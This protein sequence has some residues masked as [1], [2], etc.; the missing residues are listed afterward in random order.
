[1]RN[2]H[3]D[4]RLGLALA[5]AAVLLGLGNPGG[6]LAAQARVQ[7]ELLGLSATSYGWLL[8]AGGVGGIAVI[9]AAFWV[10][11]KPPHTIMAAG[12]LVALL[13]LSIFALPAS[14]W[15]YAAGM[16]VAGA[17]SSAVSSLIFYA[18]AV[19][20]AARYR[21][22]MIGA[23]GMV[24]LYRPNTYD[25]SD[26][27]IGDFVLFP[28]VIVASALAGAALLLVVLPRVFAGA[29]EPDQTQRASPG[30]P[31][32]WRALICAIAAYSAA[33]G[34]GIII[35]LQIFGLTE[36]ST[37]ELDA[38]GL[39]FPIAP[40]FHAVSAVS[41]LLWGAA[42]DF[43]ALR[44][45]LLLAALLYLLAASATWVSGGLPVNTLGLLAVAL[46]KGG[47]TCLPWIL[48]AELLPTR[49]FAKLAFLTTYVG[50]VAGAIPI[51][52]LLTA[53]NAFLEVVPNIF[54]VL[55]VAALA[56]SVIA[57]LMPRPQAADEFS[58][59]TL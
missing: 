58:D 13:S 2:I 22:T 59:D 15:V 1:M 12:P 53:F 47:F 54:L 18:I 26:W 8:T 10:D 24:F 25:L 55:L 32:V 20:G 44:R 4:L 6:L 36:Q 42:S 19:K 3:P 27:P 46:A 51:G 29:Y 16:F 9:A 30:A 17:G 37:S 57:V 7:H 31:G 48:M 45:W 34:A 56:L 28:P 43:L 5:A 41:I 35:D 14:M 39:E 38:L 52:L 21:G 23:L 40:V 11:R 33:S 49:N 50:G